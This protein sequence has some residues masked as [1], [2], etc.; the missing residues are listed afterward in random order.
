MLLSTCLLL[1]LTASVATST[2][3]PPGPLPEVPTPD[4]GY[5]TVADALAALRMRTDVSISTVREWLIVTDEANKTVWSFAPESYI[6]HPAVVKRSV[7][8]SPDGGSVIRMSVLCEAAKE[9][10]DQ[11]V[12]EFDAMDRRIGPR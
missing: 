7:Y 6:A 3:L 4:I 8:P 2:Q 10:C 12:R 11:L 1:C 5:R 9:A